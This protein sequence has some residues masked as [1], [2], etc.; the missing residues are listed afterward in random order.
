MKWL[1]ILVLLVC[2]CSGSTPSGTSPS[3]C[4]RTEAGQF[5]D[6]PCPTGYTCTTLV[7]DMAC[8]PRCQ[9]DADCPTTQCCQRLTDSLG[10]ARPYGGCIAPLR[11]DRNLCGGPS[12]VNDAGA[13][14][15]PAF[16]GAYGGSYTATRISDRPPMEGRVTNEPAYGIAVMQAGFTGLLFALD[17]GCSFD[18][19]GSGTRATLIPNARCTSREILNGA[20]LTVT[21]GTA[22]LAGAQL[23]VRVSFRYQLGDDSGSLAWEYTGTRR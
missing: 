1:W 5:T 18:A 22:E 14:P 16:V 15:S 23:T 8:V 2:A 10:Y 19:S 21:S 13:P 20:A 3:G 4:P 17:T 12:A 7:T 6:A 9:S 11:G